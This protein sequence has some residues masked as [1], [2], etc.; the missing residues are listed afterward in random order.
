ML[1]LLCNIATVSAQTV[2]P[3]KEYAAVL[4][5]LTAALL[6]RQISNS[7]SPDCGAINCSFCQV[8][9][10]RAAEAMYPFAIEYKI[11]KEKKYLSAAILSGNWLI[12]Q[13]QKNGSWKETPEEWTGTSTD[14]LLMMLLTYET[15]SQELTETEKQQ[16]KHSMQSAADYLATVMSP[17]FASINYVATTTATL[18]KAA[19]VLDNIKYRQK[20]AV[21]AHRVIA[22]M[23]EAGFVVGE[24]GRSHG[25]KAGVDLGYAMEMSLWGLGYYAKLTN[26]ELVNRYVKKSLKTHLYFIY[27]NGA[28]DGSWGIRS[29]KWTTYGGVTSDGCQ[30][31]FSLYADEDPRYISAALKNL[32]YLKTNM[33]NGLVGYGPQHWE[34]FNSDPC[35]Y[36]SFTK[37][38]NIALA[39]ELETKES[40]QSARIPT[41]ETGWIKNF[42]T[43]DVTEIR[44]KN[45]MAT[46]TA[47]GYKD[48]AA[49]AR[50]KYMYRPSGGA[51]SALWVKD[52]GFL[53]ASSPTV[54]SRPEPMTFPVATNTQSLSSRI[55]YTD[56]SG[57]FTNLYEFDGKMTSSKEKNNRYMV[58]VA[59][60]MKDK[61][62]LGGGVGYKMEYFFSDAEIRKNIRL[63]YHDARPQ[64]RI[65]EPIIDF[66]GT[67]FIQENDSTLIIQS[68]I[69]K[70]RFRLLGRNAKLSVGENKASYWTPFPALKAMPVLLTVDPPQKGFEQTISYSITILN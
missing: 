47:Y 70:I 16:W 46:V 17:E 13:Q 4:Q 21:L 50:S 41:E 67:K 51:I 20:A 3:R 42:P 1:A 2:Y 65:V 30:V 7:H 57:Y 10:T 37:A 31:L 59:G 43:V 60:E 55:E 12:K 52:L 9:H 49:G 28:M 25:N 39:Y 69:K 38:K 6:Q 8:L 24:G 53:Q 40:R 19:I 58:T 5:E 18:A 34:I 36:P 22:K 56:S 54:Y 23:D 11:S 32:A 61:N 62:W 26:D 14:Q 35:I 15:L 44:T 63:Q 66:S 64:I 29:N 33:R 27:P 45:F 48:Y 68:G